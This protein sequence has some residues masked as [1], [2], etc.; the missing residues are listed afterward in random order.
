[1]TEETTRVDLIRHGEPEGGPMF[2]GHRDDPL[3][4]RGERQMRRALGE[5]RPWQTLLTSPLARC[6][7]FAS[8]LARE[9]RSELVVDERFKEISFGDW[10][11]RTHAR[12][13]AEDGE[14]L[15]AFW[16]DAANNTAPNGEV[17]A[18]FHDRVVAGWR[19]WMTRLRGQHVL[20]VGHGGVIRMILAHEL[21]ME[22]SVAMARLQ[23]PYACRTQLRIDHTPYGRLASLV[24]HGVMP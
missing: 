14:R 22:P 5:A 10:E 9:T 24:W 12:V 16:S 13:Q 17:F 1:M 21:G 11:G 6:H 20:L 3:S 2:R 19:D 15:A 8:A 4:E 7:G 18:D 23:V